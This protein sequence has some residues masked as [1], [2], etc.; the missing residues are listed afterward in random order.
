MKWVLI[1][2]YLVYRGGGI[3]TVEFNNETD[4][5]A[6]RTSIRIATLDYSDLKTVCVLKRD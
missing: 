1:V 2:L 6:A 3:A 5:E 4:C